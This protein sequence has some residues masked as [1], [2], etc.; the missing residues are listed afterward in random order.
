MKIK[1]LTYGLCFFLLLPAVRAEDSA[2]RVHF[3]NAGYGDAVLLEIPGGKKVMFDAG[4]KLTRKAVADYLAGKNIKTIDTA[5]LTHP[6]ANHYEGFFRLLKYFPINRLFINGDEVHDE[7]YSLLLTRFKE[8]NIPVRVLRQGDVITDFPGDIKMEVLAPERLIT[9]IN[10]NS[11]VLKLTYRK[12]SFLFMGDTVYDAQ[13][14]LVEHYGSALQAD[15]IQIPHH[16]GPLGEEFCKL[17][18]GGKFILSTGPNQWQLFRKDP[19]E[20]MAG[21]FYRT[22]KHG[23]IVL[24][25][26]GQKWKVTTQNKLSALESTV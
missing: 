14:E 15:W 25:S 6:H 23:H 4:D 2:L 3:I 24:E 26:D 7:R 21:T 19:G 1:F 12:T 8:K 10:E 11:L 18:Q 20:L 9:G 22:D 13:K 17:F 5:V 16:G